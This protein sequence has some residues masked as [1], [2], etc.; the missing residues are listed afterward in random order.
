[1]YALRPFTDLNV[2]RAWSGEV[3][4]I[5]PHPRRIPR[6][7]HRQPPPRPRRPRAEIHMPEGVSRHDDLRSITECTPRGTPLHPGENRTAS[8]P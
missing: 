5:D 2:V 6:R 1:M 8:H 4:G 7:Q 3:V